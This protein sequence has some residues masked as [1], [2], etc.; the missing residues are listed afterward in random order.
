VK[1]TSIRPIGSGVNFGEYTPP[2][3]TVNT[4]L[5]LDFIR[6][7]SELWHWTALHFYVPRFVCLQYY[8]VK[9]YFF[10]L[11]ITN[12]KLMIL[13]NRKLYHIS[14]IIMLDK[15]IEFAIWWLTWFAESL[16]AIVIPESSKPGKLPDWYESWGIA[17]VN[18]INTIVLPEQRANI[19]SIWKGHNFIITKV[20]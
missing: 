6:Q 14:Y 19:K 17:S 16:T 11:W 2:Q 7:F 5:K 18:W 15:S 3:K 10:R 9:L 20:A 8:I 13:I 4:G 12:E 1:S